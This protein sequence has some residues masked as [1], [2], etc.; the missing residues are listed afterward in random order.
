MSI[1]ES[2]LLRKMSTQF[3]DLFAE[4]HLIINFEYNLIRCIIY[5]NINNIIIH[6][7]LSLRLTPFDSISSF[8]FEC[9]PMLL[10]LLVAVYTKHKS[11]CNHQTHN[12]DDQAIRNLCN[13]RV[14]R[15]NLM[16]RKGLGKMLTKKTL[17]K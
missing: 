16:P 10:S 11:L 4:N 8:V 12:L 6:F 2:P 15:N 5:Y 9:F 13:H 17:L 3:K 14:L 7:L 1:K